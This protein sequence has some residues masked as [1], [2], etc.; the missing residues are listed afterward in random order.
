MRWTR[1]AASPPNWR[2]ITGPR[3]S[4]TASR[5]CGPDDG[6]P[7]DGGTP[8]VAPRRAALARRAGSVCCAVDGFLFGAPAFIR[9]GVSVM[10]ILRG[11]NGVLIML[12]WIAGL[13]AL[14]T[15]WWYGRRL[16]AA[17]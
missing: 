15:A 2:G 9:R 5:S 12:L 1:A 14:C 8:A 4:S 10:S 11:P 3:P 6:R 16:L 17:A 13:A 7:D